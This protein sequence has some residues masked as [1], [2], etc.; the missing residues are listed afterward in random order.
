MAPETRRAQRV[1]ETFSASRNAAACAA[2][3]RPPSLHE[4][5]AVILQRA[6]Q[7]RD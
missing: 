3:K 1:A 7:H 5:A 2:S 4:G 6:G